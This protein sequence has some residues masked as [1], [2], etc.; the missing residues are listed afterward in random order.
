MKHVVT[1]TLLLAALLT[2]ISASRAQCLSG[3][4]Y[5]GAFYPGHGS[6]TTLTQGQTLQGYYY[7]YWSIPGTTF[8]LQWSTNYGSTWTTIASGIPM[9]SSYTY[10]YFTYTVP[11]TFPPS[12][13]VIT[14]LVQSSATTCY[15]RPQYYYSYHTVI[16][17]CINPPITQQPQDI[18]TCVG[19]TA[20]FTVGAPV[21]QYWTYKWFKNGS[22]YSTAGPDLTISNVQLGDAGKYKLT[23]Y[24]VCGK[25]ST[26]N[27]VTLTVMSPA[28]I[29][30]QPENTIICK[31]YDGELSVDATGS[32][33]T[34]QWYKD[35]QAI[36]GA[37]QKKLT[38]TIAKESDNGMYYATVASPCGVPAVSNTV[39]LQVPPK[40]ELVTQP[41]GGAYCPGSSTTLSLVATG[42]NLSYQW[43][44]NDNPIQGAN[45][46]N[47]TLASLN[48]SHDGFYWCEIDIPGVQSSTGCDVRVRSDR[49]F[50]N[51]HTA[52]VIREQPEG[53]EVC[54]GTNVQLDAVAEGAGLTYQW[55]RNG[56]PIAN[57][58][59]YSYTIPAAT[60]SASGTYTVTVTG[61]CGLSATSTAAVVNVYSQPTVTKHPGNANVLLGQPI[62]LTVEGTG[63]QRVSW[64]HNEQPIEGAEGATLTIPSAM[65]EHAGWYRAL[66]HNP[67]GG[68]TSRLARVT[69]TDPASLEPRLS[70]EEPTIDFGEVPYGYS[71]QQM[72]S[73][74]VTNNG[75]VP[76]ELTGASVT[77]AD[78]S[79]FTPTLSVAPI[80]LQPGEK[81]N[82]QITFTPTKVGMAEATLSIE[83][84]AT[85]GPHSIQLEGMGVVRYTI[86]GELAFGTVDKRSTTTKCFQLNNTSAMDIAIDDVMFA[87][88][89]ASSFKL[90]SALPLMISAGS[91][92]ELCVEFSPS[93][94][95]QY[96]ANV[97][98]KSAN[99]GDVSS[100][101]SG[102]CEIASSVT[103]DGH[104]A[105]IVVYPNPASSTVTVQFGQVQATNLKIVSALGQVINSY[106]VS[107]G[108][109]TWDG[110]D[111]NGTAVPSGTYVL[112]ITSSDVVYTLPLMVVR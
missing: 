91:T 37:N 71:G 108:T 42:P 40:A 98:F 15:W 29:T 51:V 19:S 43:Y 55:F 104:A 14:R 85:N 105:G 30:K 79:A 48:S 58:T 21:G 18:T 101:A 7:T 89:G 54:A 34:I 9:A 35:G 103:M 84:E 45:G 75:I 112:C 69:V 5:M 109:M 92:K 82:V 59:N 49:A 28:A 47:L 100:S 81:A 65:M 95:G 99:G 61:V 13:N 24:D 4:Y 67:C 73:A 44:Q 20:T 63:L 22:D 68:A 87:G 23:I 102:T 50:V 74:V 6:Y 76:V 110:L 16:R 31:G 88:G 12:S 27:E 39:Q 52:P 3:S 25:S 8:Q 46:P 94:V 70:V 107:S 78:A 53:M 33:L 41:Q 17:A 86:D 111:S 90:S 36:A 57:A 62:Q 77:G 83:S 56:A 72:F 106:D 64:L 93:D 60:S 2:G 11:T 96:A 66:I 10:Y 97:T 80:T 32:P 26:T 38:F 1:T